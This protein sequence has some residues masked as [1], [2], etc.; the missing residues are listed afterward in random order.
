MLLEVNIASSWKSGQE[1]MVLNPAYCLGILA[2][3]LISLTVHFFVPLTYVRQNARHWFKL[4]SKTY[5][6]APL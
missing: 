5:T 2:L 6:L 1:H 3:L 4:G